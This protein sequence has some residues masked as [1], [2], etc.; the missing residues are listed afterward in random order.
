MKSIQYLHTVLF[1]LKN[2]EIN[3]NGFEASLKKFM[4]DSKYA[5]QYFYGKPPKAEREV[6]D[7]SYHFKLSVGFTSKERHDAYQVEKA[8]ID[9]IDEA[10]TLWD[11]VQVYD[12]LRS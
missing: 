4:N 7:D 3:E 8:H 6:V 10:S 11:K 1:W 12:A 2:P 9:F 5:D